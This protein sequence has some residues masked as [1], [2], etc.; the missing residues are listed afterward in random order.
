VTGRADPSN[1][2][3]PFDQA[4]RTVTAFGAVRVPFEGFKALRKAPGPLPPGLD[5]LPASLL[6]HADH[7]TLLAIAA[8][9]RASQAFGLDG[10]FHDWGVI[11]APRF[12]GR[13]GVA[14]AMFKFLQMGATGVSPLIIPTMSLHAVSGSLSM[15]IKAHGF[16]IGVG[17]GPGHLAEGLTAGL[18][19]ADAPGL[20]GVW[21]VATGFDPEPVPDIS[22]DVLT[23]TTGYGV[24][25]AL[26]AGRDAA[27]GPGRTM[28]RLAE[29]GA[30]VALSGPASDANGGEPLT[31]LIALADF[32]SATPAT[33]AL[34]RWQCPLPGIGALVLDDDPA[35]GAG[36]GDSRRAG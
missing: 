33:K 13:V 1:T 17:G 31:P 9:F 34:R 32:L 8:V 11:A 26:S 35:R 4:A 27:G 29:G 6:K 3:F 36:H 23:A 25:L 28:L 22:G 12:L 10:P 15:A 19:S 20:A 18:S 14:G 21:I 7:Q 30:A 5:K 2:T 24:A 16:N